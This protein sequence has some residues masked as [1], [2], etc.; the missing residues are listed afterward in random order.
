MNPYDPRFSSNNPQQVLRDTLQEVEDYKETN[1]GLC[2]EIEQLQNRVGYI[3]LTADELQGIH[4]LIQSQI[5]LISNLQN[6]DDC[7]KIH[8]A[9]TPLAILI[10]LISKPTD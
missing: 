10:S 3:G 4:R 8:S 1:Q 2:K 6:Q 7:L 9:V 5:S